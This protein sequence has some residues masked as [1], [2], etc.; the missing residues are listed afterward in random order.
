MAMLLYD[1]AGDNDRRFSP[2]CW[3]VRMALA[4]KGQTFETVP[5]P[6]TGIGSICDGSHKTVPVLD[7]DGT[8]LR[9]SFVIAEYLEDTF[10]QAPSL[11]GGSGGRAVSKVVEASIAATLVPAIAS[12]CVHDIHEAALP[13]DRDYFRQSREARFGRSLE[14]F[15][16]GREERRD[17]LTKALHPFRMVLRE[18]DWLGG[19]GALFVDY[20]LFGTMQWPRVSSAFPMLEA[21][22]P[23]TQWFE[24]MLD[25]HGGIGRAMPAAA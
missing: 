12:L 2:Y 3:R 6:F 19:D 5:V 21:D 11:F 10:P 24:R 20:M 22:D 16:A 9:D 23:V 14:A 7:H 25:L 8:I 4:H 15:Q 1:L 13:Q 17:V 18:R